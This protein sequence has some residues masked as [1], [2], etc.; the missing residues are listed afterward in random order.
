MDFTIRRG[1]DISVSEA[2]R[3]DIENGSKIS[4]VALSGRDFH[5]IR[6][7]TLVELGDQV[8][9]GEPLFFDR[10]RAE[11]I[12]S[13]PAS[14]VVSKINYTHRRNLDSI[15]ITCNGKAAIS[16]DITKEV[17]TVL[18][19]SG[20]WTAFKTR[21]FGLIP[22]PDAS[23][24]SI[25]VSAMDSNP[26]AADPAIIL[27]AAQESFVRGLDV[28]AELNQMQVIVCHGADAQ[29]AKHQ[30]KHISYATFSGRHPA[31]LPGTHLNSLGLSGK[32][33][34]QIGYEDVISI[35]HL[36]LNGQLSNERVISVAGPMVRNPRLLRTQ[37]GA[38]L[39]DLLDGELKDGAFSIISGSILSGRASSYLG[40]YDTQ[41]SVLPKLESKSRTCFFSQLKGDIATPILPSE[42]FETVMPQ[43]ILPIPLM[44]ALAVGDWETAQKLGCLDLLEEDVALLS[45]LCS[46]GTDYSALLRLALDNLEKE[47]R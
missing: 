6:F 20:L 42:I 13:A 16:F 10:N 19:E 29:L 11:I 34:W 3:Q 44:R 35:G 32:S 30:N 4:C 2:P 22:D 24:Q 33:V 7:E 46:S 21:P 12:F 28:L 15:I 40:H 1:L 37:R 41:I 38:N 25:L 9:I 14:G 8:A 31:G 18:L 26:L 39:I 23:A 43:N 36:F 27:Q 17:R 47:I 45:Y 5:N